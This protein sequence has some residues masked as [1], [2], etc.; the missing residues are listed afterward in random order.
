[1]KPVIQPSATP[2]KTPLTDAFISNIDAPDEAEEFEALAWWA[3]DLEMRLAAK[4]KEIADLRET[5]SRNLRND[6]FNDTPSAPTQDGICPQCGGTVADCQCPNN[7]LWSIIKECMKELEMTDKAPSMLRA[8]IQELKCDNARLKA[9]EVAETDRAVLLLVCAE[10][11]EA[12]AQAI[13]DAA[14]I[15]ADQLNSRVAELEQALALIDTAR[16][17]RP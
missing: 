3:R 2:N 6:G 9:K 12:R 1:M 17:A 13:A 8:E 10:K 14:K 5:V 11:A 4:D 16:K 15:E 7:P